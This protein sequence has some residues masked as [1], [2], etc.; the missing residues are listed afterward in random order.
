MVRNPG[1][2]DLY[3][4]ARKLGRRFISIP[5]TLVVQCVMVDST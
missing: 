1:G 2:M 3:L 5:R 4:D